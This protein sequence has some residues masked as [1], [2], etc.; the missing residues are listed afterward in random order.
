MEQLRDY[1]SYIHAASKLVAKLRH[2][3]RPT[4]TEAHLAAAIRTYRTALNPSSSLDEIHQAARSGGP[5]GEELLLLLDPQANTILA[6]V[7][8]LKKHIETTIH[9]LAPPH[10][11][12]SPQSHT[13]QPL[14]VVERLAKAFPKLRPRI[15]SLTEEGK[16]PTSDPSLLTDITHRYWSN[17]WRRVPL[18]NRPARLFSRYAKPIRVQ[19]KTITKD[20]VLRIL[21]ET[22][23]S[24]AGPNNIPF[25]AYR[26]LADHFA[27]VFLTCVNELMAG[28]LPHSDFNSG[29]LHLIEKKATGR[30][31]D[32]RPIVVSNADNRIIASIIRWAIT[33]C[34]EAIIDHHQG[35]FLPGRSMLAH[36]EFFNERFYKALEEG[37][38]Y[39]IIFFD[40]AKAFDSCSHVALFAALTAAGLPQG[41]INAIRGLFHQAHC[42]TNFKG[43]TPRKFF[44]SSGI[45]QGCPLSPLL[46]VLMI[47][48][49]STMVA[50]HLPNIDFKLFAD[51][52]AAGAP[53]L[54]PHIATLRKIFKI[55]EQNTNLGLNPAKSFYVS[56]LSRPRRLPI[57]TALRRC[58]WTQ[59]QYSGS[60]SYLGVPFG[61]DVEVA[62]A[63]RTGFAK[64]RASLLRY[65]P[66]KPRISFG[67]RILITNV[68]LLP[69]FSYPQK[70][71]IWPRYWQNAVTSHI[72]GWLNRFNSLSLPNMHTP[73]GQFG[74]P[75]PLTHFLFLNY[76]SLASAAK[77]ANYSP[78]PSGDEHSMRII[79]HR[80]LAVRFISSNFHLEVD[81]FLG[82]QQG[83]IYKMILNSP[84]Y[85]TH[86]SQAFKTEQL[87]KW[88]TPHSL[89]TPVSDR[90]V[91]LPKWSPP[92]A[93]VF[94]ILITH[95][96]LPTSDRLQHLH[97][98]GRG[99]APHIAPG[100]PCFLCNAEVDSGRHL[101]Q[102]CP[103]VLAALGLLHTALGFLQPHPTLTTLRAWTTLEAPPL[104][105]PNL[106][107]IMIL[108]SFA[109]WNLRLQRENCSHSGA[110]LDLAIYNDAMDRI[111]F[112]GSAV[113]NATCL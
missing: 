31:S 76:A 1:N 108:F 77:L 33:P 109:A 27:P 56:T 80:Q 30:I 66:Y 97:R 79:V 54:F 82:K 11:Q 52:T 23:H 60:T 107:G 32:T 90:Y 13:T 22:K 12:D 19:P 113:L 64:F 88:G 112:H 69:L 4:G 3:D 59:I 53:R 17:H 75:T 9:S 38:P 73:T 61:Q 55:F 91:K 95:N 45:K 94:F 50:T 51:D 110:S 83:V 106:A 63:F 26:A 36:I 48:T 37:E 68:F 21:A 58:G 2:K 89:I 85:R 42:L 43:A 41:I 34:I 111:S 16:E 81:S 5:S 28:D 18:R 14:S 71:F 24:A 62:D 84:T 15:S 96:S 74:L 44:F 6:S 20:D 105:D 104:A 29:I 86:W 39:D 65:L 93:K 8:R 46:F 40:F 67:K 101:Y 25:A 7:A 57:R 99:P 98:G 72:W 10:T 87:T 70:F 35:G 49:L 100:L 47:N 103:T 92:Y 78:A 102:G